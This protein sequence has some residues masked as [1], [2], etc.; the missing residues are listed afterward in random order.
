MIVSIKECALCPNKYRHMIGKVSGAILCLF[1]MA[2]CS[3]KPAQQP[4]IR[5]VKAITIS[6]EQSSVV[7]EFSGEI[8]PKIESKLGF[9]V[10][11]KII[12]RKVEVGDLVQPKQVLM[13]LDAQDL[14][15]MQQQANSALKAALSNRDLA[16]AELYRYQELREK[17]F[18]NQATLDAKTTAYQSAQSNYEQA[19][20][21][22]RNQS[23][24]TG[25]STLVADISGVVTSI[26]GEVGQVVAAGTP[27][28]SV[29]QLGDKDV[30]ISVPENKVDTLKQVQAVYIRLWAQP[31]H[32]IVGHIREI[33]PVADPVTRTYLVKITMP[34]TSDEVKLG[35]TAY[36]SLV[37]SNANQAITLPLTALYKQGDK[38]AVWLVRDGQVHLT[39]ITLSGVSGNDVVVSA[40]IKS[41]DVVVIAGVNMLQ[42]NQKVDVLNPV[43]SASSSDTAHGAA[44]EK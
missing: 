29:A 41:G 6:S 22:S 11:G 4:D 3:E 15:L 42:E 39:P 2:A 25:Y 32:K 44:H 28:V 21:A 7:D 8:K 31:D 38:T 9:R 34:D 26:N 10:G 24:Q 16:Q 27:V 23:N 1:L 20:A 18:V 14:R 33:S 13:Q 37:N 19:L 12:A 35:M 36:V 43:A 17:N 40:G 30:V 5:A